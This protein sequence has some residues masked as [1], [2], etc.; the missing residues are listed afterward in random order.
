[1]H[2][3]A[4]SLM[5]LIIFFQSTTFSSFKTSL[6]YPTTVSVESETYLDSSF[7]DDDPRLNLPRY[8]FL[9]AHNPNNPKR[10][11]ICV[12]FK[13]LLTVRSVTSPTSKGMPFIKGFLRSFIIKIP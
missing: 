12:Y 6:R 1:M 11:G 8:Y 10:S 7:P 13:E 3:K 2:Y 5:A 4:L 9:R